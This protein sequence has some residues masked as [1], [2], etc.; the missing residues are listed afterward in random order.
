MADTA[1][2]PAE[3]SSNDITND[4]NPTANAFTDTLVG[5][6]KKFADTE[7]LAKGKYE[8][9]QFV[10]QLQSENKGLREEL[11]KRATAEDT[12][13][14]LI[15]ERTQAAAHEGVTT[16]SQQISQEGIAELVKQTMQSQKS[17]DVE[18]NNI[19]QADKAMEDRFGEKKAEWLNSKA[20]E[21]GVGITF[22]QSIAAASP[23]TFLKTV[24]LDNLSQGQGTVPSGSINTEALSSTPHSQGATPGTM[25]YY[26]GLR[27][28]DPRKFWQPKIQQALMKDRIDMGE[29]KFYA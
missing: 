3:E 24:G 7:A 15:Q 9:D 10:E 11:D 12:V 6:G 8:A 17:A 5:E 21:L 26:E 25:A 22:L 1:F 20:K 29:E 14:K 18:Q 2:Q 16:P 27:K 4:V 19:L 23:T 28:A 13:D